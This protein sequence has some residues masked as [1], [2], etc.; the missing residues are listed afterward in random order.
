MLVLKELANNLT[1][2][3]MLFATVH[4]THLYNSYTSFSPPGASIVL[5]M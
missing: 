5:S 2:E 4:F 1:W 3:Q